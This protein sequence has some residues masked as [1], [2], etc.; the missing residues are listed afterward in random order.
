MKTLSGLER[1]TFWRDLIAR[2]SHRLRAY[3]RRAHCDDAADDILWDVWQVATERE[4]ELILST[5]CWSILH[6]IVKTV[7]HVWK[8]SERRERPLEPELM[9]PEEPVDNP[10]DV[11]ARD[12]LIEWT[13]AALGDL[14]DKQRMAVDYRFRWNWPY[15]IVAAAIDASEPTTRVHVMRGLARLR[16]MA[17]RREQDTDR[18][19]DQR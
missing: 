13:L 5:D 3:I 8:R 4:S 2:Y 7:I 14:T 12:E 19:D 9:R 6:E 15:R 10:E 11:R 18:S 16:L 1:E 17:A